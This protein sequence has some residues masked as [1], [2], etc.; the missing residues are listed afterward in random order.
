MPETLA[1]ADQA[2]GVFLRKHARQ[3][4][5]PFE[6]ET[7]GDDLREISRAIEWDLFRNYQLRERAVGL[8]RIV[9]AMS[10]ADQQLPLSFVHLSMAYPR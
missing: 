3:D 4:L 10:R 8:V 6:M 1:L 9:S 2:R 7:P 5:S